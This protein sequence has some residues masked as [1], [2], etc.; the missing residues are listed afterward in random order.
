MVVPFGKRR[1]LAGGYFT[2]GSGKHLPGMIR[3]RVAEEDGRDYLSQNGYIL[4][5]TCF[6]Y[7]ELVARRHRCP[8]ENGEVV[9]RPDHIDQKAIR[10]DPVH[11]AW[12]CCVL[13]YDYD[14]VCC[15]HS[16]GINSNSEKSPNDT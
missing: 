14:I 16:N 1:V 2:I 7:M 5:D 3:N 12:C 15:S 8:G 4:G 10:D 11:P 13:S 6:E 9:G